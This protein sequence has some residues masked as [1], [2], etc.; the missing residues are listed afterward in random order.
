MNPTRIKSYDDLRPIPRL[1]PVLF[2]FN[3]LQCPTHSHSIFTTGVEN[4]VPKC[5]VDVAPQG[6]GG[7]PGK[8]EDSIKGQTL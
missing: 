1:C 6:Q 3:V 4:S 2:V 8:R 7:L 5:R